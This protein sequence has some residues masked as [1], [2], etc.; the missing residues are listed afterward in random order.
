MHKDIGR[1]VMYKGRICT[2][3]G[4]TLSARNCFGG[5]AYHLMPDGQRDIRCLI[6]Y[7]TPPHLAFDPPQDDEKV[8]V[9]HG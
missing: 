2:V 9:L 5:I 7:V 6:Q 1:K 3:R 4:V 8:V